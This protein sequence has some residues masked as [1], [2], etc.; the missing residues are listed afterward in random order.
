MNISI[1]I[2]SI[3]FSDVKDSVENFFKKLASKVLHKDEDSYEYDGGYRLV[4]DFF[5]GN[6]V[7]LAADVLG[8]EIS[9]DD[10]VL[11]SSSGALTIEN[12][13]N[14]I[15]DFS[16][17]YGNTGLYAYV[18][19]DAGIVDGR[20]FVNF[21]IIIGVDHQSNDLIAGIGGASLWGGAGFSADILTGNLGIDNFIVG[22]NEGNDHIANADSNDVI[23]LHDV[24]L[25]DIVNTAADGKLIGV[26]F[27]TGFVMTVES[28]DNV[29]P[30]F[31]LSDGT[32]YAYNHSTSAWQNA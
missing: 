30:I 7:K 2:G 16:D 23:D 32:R 25:S 18:A 9:D 8:I 26:A 6:K 13:R 12:G 17:T 28:K 4:K 14:K 29:S 22:K 31:Q 10:F 19:G 3:S 21:E 11:N 1:G 24:T 15:I 27:N 20:A 5:S